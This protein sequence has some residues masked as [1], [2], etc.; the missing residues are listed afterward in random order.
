MSETAAEESPQTGP[1]YS[2]LA[3]AIMERATTAREAVEIIGA[4][5]DSP[6]QPCEMAN[7]ARTLTGNNLAAV[8]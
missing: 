3:K 6:E 1:Q 4:L 2:D 8:S 7:S 5:I